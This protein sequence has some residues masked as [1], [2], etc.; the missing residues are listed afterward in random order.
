MMLELLH[1]VILQHRRQCIVSQ[2]TGLHYFLGTTIGEMTVQLRHRLLVV[3]TC[4][5]SECIK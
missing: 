1:V 2:P 3:A 4:S 5:Y